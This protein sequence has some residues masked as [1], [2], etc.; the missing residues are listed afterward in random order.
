MFEFIKKIFGFSPRQLSVAHIDC[1]RFEVENVLKELP[2]IYMSA[3]LLIKI[4]HEISEDLAN[5]FLEQLAIKNLKCK[6]TTPLSQKKII[7]IFAVGVMFTLAACGS[8]STTE[9]TTDSVS[10]DTT[11][12]S[13]TDSTTATADSSATK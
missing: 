8:K 7:L 9:G 13:A 6:M 11:A 3:T 5:E 12:V 2:P 4:P 1:I 10:I